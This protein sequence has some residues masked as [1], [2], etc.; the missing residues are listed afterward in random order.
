MTTLGKMKAQSGLAL[1][2]QHYKLLGTMEVVVNRTGWS[3]AE[4]SSTAVAC[5]Q[6]SHYNYNDS[7]QSFSDK[8]GLKVQIPCHSCRA[9]GVNST[10]IGINQ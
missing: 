7:C 5:V 1:N 6:A 3:H 8:F 4:A 10:E 2:Y 9:Q